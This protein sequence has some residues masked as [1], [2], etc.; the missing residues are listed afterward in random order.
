MKKRT[1]PQLRHGK[2][3]RAVGPTTA[4]VEIVTVKQHPKYHKRFMRSQRVLVQLKRGQEVTSGQSATIA[5]TR[6]RS[7]S[8][9]WRMA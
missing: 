3:V 8:K 9:R 5:L 4:V 1:L 7:G 6:P 2:V